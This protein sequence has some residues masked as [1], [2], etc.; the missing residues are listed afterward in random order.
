MA[1]NIVTGSMRKVLRGA[2]CRIATICKC[3]GY[4]KVIFYDHYQISWILGREE[5][6]IYIISSLTCIE[7]ILSSPTCIHK[8][9]LVGLVI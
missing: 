1:V 3:K 4:T 7:Y 5:V 9:D 2:G 6:L 8:R